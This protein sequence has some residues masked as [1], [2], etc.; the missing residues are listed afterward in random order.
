MSFPAMP[1]GYTTLNDLR[2]K[3]KAQRGVGEQ[4]ATQIDNSIACLN[5][6]L[7]R[8][9]PPATEEEWTMLFRDAKLRRVMQLTT[10]TQLQRQREK[11]EIIG[12]TASQVF[13]GGEHDTALFSGEGLDQDGPLTS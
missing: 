7:A 1:E 3:I 4:S 13:G 2:A 5:A 6:V 8:K 11:A 9:E 12:T 10:A